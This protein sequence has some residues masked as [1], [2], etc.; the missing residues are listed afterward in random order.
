MFF[1]SIS[2]SLFSQGIEF[3][4]EPLQAPIGNVGLLII[5]GFLMIAKKYIDDRKE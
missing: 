5:I 2:S 1:L 4:E 3:P